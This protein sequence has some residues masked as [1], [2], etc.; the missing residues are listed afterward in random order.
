[1]RY[2]D[3]NLIA[4]HTAGLGVLMDTKDREQAF[5]DGHKDDVISFYQHK[6]NRNVIYTSEMGDKSTV[7]AWKAELGEQP[8]IVKEFKGARKGVS[9]VIGNGTYVVAA[10]L[11]DNHEIYLW[12]YQTGKLI[13]NEKG[14]REVIIAIDWVS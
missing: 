6:K 7:F 9:A 10:C 11:D 8:E 5:F 3:G 12:N 4:Y 1:M 14:G 2:I 13:K